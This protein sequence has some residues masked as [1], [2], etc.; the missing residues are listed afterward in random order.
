MA[1]GRLQHEGKRLHPTRTASIA[2]RL[3][4]PNAVG[5]YY[6][7][8]TGQ[9]LTVDPDIDQTG[10][11]YAYVGG[12]PVNSADPSGKDDPGEDFAPDG[13]S[14]GVSQGGGWE[15]PGNISAGSEASTDSPSDASNGSTQGGETSATRLGRLAHSLIQAD[16]GA[17]WE[18]EYYLGSAG[19]A[20]SVN[21]ADREVCGDQAKQRPCY[22]SGTSPAS[23]LW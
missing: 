18:S 9:F 22:S 8:Q 16:L 2:A 23:P 14:G 3:A 17:D 11:A 13:D 10:Q 1:P 4:H 5:R 12:D 7:P 15:G 21:I 19:R 20:D 6:D